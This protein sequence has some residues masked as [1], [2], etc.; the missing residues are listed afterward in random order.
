MCCPPT[1][2]RPRAPQALGVLLYVLVYG[3]LP[4]EA[5]SKLSVLFG[6]YTLPPG[7]PAVLVDLI[8]DLLVRVPQRAARPAGRMLMCRAV[9]WRSGRMLRASVCASAWL[10]AQ[11]CFPWMIG[12]RE[13]T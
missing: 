7:K 2:P 8:R 6:K 10:L 4:F 5:D 12:G 11:H 13:G 1:F 9:A 3:K